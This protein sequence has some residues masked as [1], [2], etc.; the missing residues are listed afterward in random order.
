MP[1]DVG[2]F[3]ARINPGRLEDKM[4][5][6]PEGWSVR[7]ISS[8]DLA[9]AMGL[10]E[11]ASRGIEGARTATETTAR[12]NMPG[13]KSVRR[14]YESGTAVAHVEIGL[15]PTALLGTGR[16]REAIK[17]L[18]AAELAAGSRPW[19]NV[20]GVTFDV[21]PTGSK[22]R[23]LLGRI[24]SQMHLS[25]MTTAEDEDALA[26]LAG[27][28]FEGLNRMLD[29]PVPGI[30][31]GPVELIK[32]G[33]MTTPPAVMQG[34]MS[35]EALLLAFSAM[36]QGGGAGQA[37]FEGLQTGDI[38]GLPQED[39]A[40]LMVG[41]FKALEAALSQG[42]MKSALGNI[43]AG[44][45]ANLPPEELAKVL[46]TQ[47]SAIRSML[48]SGALGQMDPAALSALGAGTF[49]GASQEQIATAIAGQFSAIA[50]AIETA[51]PLPV[52]AASAP[53]AEAGTDGGAGG[54]LLSGLFSRFKGTETAS[55]E[56]GSLPKVRSGTGGACTTEGAGKFCSV[57]GN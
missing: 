2:E 26:I 8:G 47:F 36:M 52:E 21:A 6:A 39:L 11:S 46:E 12:L 54:G 56:G 25:V 31:E 24:G 33:T 38:A 57:G 41:Q 22:G 14:M 37:G 49:D 4:P 20:K 42:G 43:G 40:R 3:I 16:D 50:K 45:M 1:A 10:P 13:Y 53:S 28:D 29:V 5:P 35:P 9:M 51:E 30:G 23:A 15:V 17:L 27:I 19:A 32:G 44:E 18:R 7:R 55:A 48:E 34:G